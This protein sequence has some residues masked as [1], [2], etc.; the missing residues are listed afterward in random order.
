MPRSFP[1]TLA[2]HHRRID[3]SEWD[4]VYVV[5]DVHGCLEAL[6]R[7]VDA[8]ALSPDD[9]L[10]FVGDLVQKGP[11]SAGVVERVR[12]AENMCSVRGNSEEQLLGGDAALPELDRDALAWIESLPIAISWDGAL[13]VHGGVDP[14]TPLAAHSAADLQTMRATVPGGGYDGPLWFESYEGPPRV[15]FGHTVLDEPL[16]TEWAVGLDTGC[17]CGGSLTAYCVGDGTV[18][19]VPGRQPGLERD[20]SRIVST[21]HYQ[22]V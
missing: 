5:G 13:V 6:D 18:H 7:L 17:V 9:L 1:P 8:V 21:A 16:V 11:D 22:D 20:D 19:Q 15:F 2:E 4:G 3:P 14:D 12:S 10:V